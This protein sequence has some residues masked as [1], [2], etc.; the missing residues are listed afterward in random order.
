M[1]L[2]TSFTFQIRFLQQMNLIV[3]SSIVAAI[4]GHRLPMWQS[5]QIF[6]PSRV[7]NGE[8]SDHFAAWF[9]LPT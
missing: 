1:A 7:A 5:A 4:A 9:A 8:T 3:S 6:Y 2:I